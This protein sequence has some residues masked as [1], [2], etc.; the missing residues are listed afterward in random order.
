MDATLEYMRGA[1]NIIRGRA[2]AEREIA[3]LYGKI[4]ERA[5]EL[6][7]LEKADC[8]VRAAEVVEDFIKRAEGVPPQASPFPL[9]EHGLKP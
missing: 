6:H 4:S 1:A 2:K 5:V 9:T 3:T 7:Y 8:Y